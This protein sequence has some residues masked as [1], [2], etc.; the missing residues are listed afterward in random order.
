MPLSNELTWQAPIG[1]DRIDLT[2][3]ADL[4][5]WTTEL[6]CD[7]HELFSA[8]QAVGI[9]V[10]ALTLHLKKQSPAAK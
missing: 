3:N 9:R 10:D 5:F 6:A 4:T 2:D 1:A 7:P 8:V